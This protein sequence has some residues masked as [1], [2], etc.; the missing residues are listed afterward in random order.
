MRFAGAALI[1]LFT[2]TTSLALGLQGY[3]LSAVVVILTGLAGLLGWL[4]QTRA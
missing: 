1:L 3:A 4:W 2:A